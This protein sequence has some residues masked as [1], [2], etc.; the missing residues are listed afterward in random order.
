MTALVTV[1]TVATFVYIVFLEQP[2]AHDR[3]IAWRLWRLRRH[4]D[5]CDECTFDQIQVDLRT[6]KTRTACDGYE[7]AQKAHLL[8]LN[9]CR[10]DIC[11]VHARKLQE[12]MHRFHRLIAAIWDD[13]EFGC[14]DARCA[15]LRA[16]MPYFRCRN[17]GDDPSVRQH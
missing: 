3:W 9:T 5:D 15:K 14:D 6:G 8:M 16:Q 7:L 1:V 11:R 12:H 2:K 4:F 13:E 17:I 10:F